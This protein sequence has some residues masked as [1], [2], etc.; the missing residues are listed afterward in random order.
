MDAKEIRRICEL[1]ENTLDG[2]QDR[3]VVLR[4]TSRSKLE[5]MDQQLQELQ[6]ALEAISQLSNAVVTMLPSEQELQAQISADIGDK[7]RETQRQIDEYRDRLDEPGLHPK[8][9]EQWESMLRISEI[10]HETWIRH[11]ATELAALKN[12]QMVDRITGSID[13]LFTALAAVKIK[14]ALADEKLLLQL[15]MQTI[16]NS[17]R[18]AVES[19]KSTFDAIEQLLI[20]ALEI[21]GETV[22][23]LPALLRMRRKLA[24]NEFTTESDVGLL[25]AL[26]DEWNVSY[27]RIKPFVDYILFC[28]RPDRFVE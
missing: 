10:Q 6:T 4:D 22:D 13:E 7:M 15:H 16:A 3:H 11:A 14:I 5:R 27:A 21:P 19:P 25:V 24:R 9:H 28:R 1:L 2:F 26:A 8:V 12:G 18:P 23:L 20:A 17:L